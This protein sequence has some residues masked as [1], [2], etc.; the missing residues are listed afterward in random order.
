MPAKMNMETKRN[1]DDEPKLSNRHVYYILFHLLE[2][3]LQTTNILSIK[4]YE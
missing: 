2:L 4:S 1:G 3:S